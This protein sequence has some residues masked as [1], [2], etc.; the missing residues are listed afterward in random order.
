M[1]AD[2]SETLPHSPHTRGIIQHFE[3]QVRLHT[4][5]LNEDIQVTNDRIGQLES[6]QILAKTS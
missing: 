2:A 4:D 5:A 1:S 3:R 6:V